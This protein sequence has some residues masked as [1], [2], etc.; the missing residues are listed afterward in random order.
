MSYT[1]VCKLSSLMEGDAA[2]YNVDGRE[3]ILL[4]AEGGELQAF[5]GL[6]PHQNVP[7]YRGEFNGRYLTCPVH[8]WVFDGRDG[9]C[10]RGEE[11]SLPKIA[12][13]VV[14]G[15]VEIESRASAAS[16]AA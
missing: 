6:C 1:P 12:L 8:E 5:N 10:V 16:S 13:R 11:C 7:L 9:S 2:P 4:W 3:V 14:N 15:I